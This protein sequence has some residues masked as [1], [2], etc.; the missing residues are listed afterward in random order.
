M[1]GQVMHL[2]ITAIKLSY[3]LFSW[4]KN[5]SFQCFALECIHICR[6]V[7]KRSGQHWNDDGGQAILNFKAM[8]L[9]KRLNDAWKMIETFYHHPI[10]PPKNVIKFIPKW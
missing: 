7:V 4:G 8:L 3:L 10:D 5:F 6:I 1:T 2:P 9:S